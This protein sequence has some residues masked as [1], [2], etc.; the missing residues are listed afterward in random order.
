MTPIP[1]RAFT[2]QDRVNAASRP[3][4]DLQVSA[5]DPE[6]RAAACAP[7]GK[8][9]GRAVPSDRV[10]IVRRGVVQAR[11]PVDLGADG[12]A[13]FRLGGPVAELTAT[14]EPDVHRA[15]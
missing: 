11:D 13:W 8:M 5:A 3:L 2:F 9:R 12:L 14:A 6:A 10:G 7:A 15:A 1:A 4:T